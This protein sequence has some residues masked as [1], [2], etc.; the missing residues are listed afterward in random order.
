MRVTRFAL[1]AAIAALVAS[2][3]AAAEPKTAAVEFDP[4]VRLKAGDEFID[5]GEE[6]G[7]SGPLVAD[8][9]SD[10]KPDLL[11]GNFS[12]HIQLYMNRGTRREPKYVD[13]GLLQAEGKDVKIPNW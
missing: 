13:Q 10:G 8:L 1:A 3:A 12:G 7:H 11:V 9:D 4:P 5:S 2:Q 6:T